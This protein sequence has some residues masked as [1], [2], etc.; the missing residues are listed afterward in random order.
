MLS[1]GEPQ[2]GPTQALGD[3]R[4]AQSQTAGP[5]IMPGF[6][7]VWFSPNG[8]TSGRHQREQASPCAKSP[9]PSGACMLGRACVGPCVHK[10]AVG[11]YLSVD[12][13][14]RA[15]GGRGGRV[16]ALTNH[17]LHTL[18]PAGPAPKMSLQVAI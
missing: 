18:V 5:L 14:P 6:I 9:G 2:S 8:N 15:P 3:N 17:D 1:R 7:E 10:A 11:N 4:R 12:Q 16:V 13:R